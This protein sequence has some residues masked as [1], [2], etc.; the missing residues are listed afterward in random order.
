MSHDILRLFENRSMPIELL[1][2]PIFLVLLQT[3]IWD[4]QSSKQLARR[5]M[6][7][8]ARVGPEFIASARADSIVKAFRLRIWF[9][10]VVEVLAYVLLS[11]RNSLGPDYSV[12]SILILTLTSCIGNS[13]MFGLANREAKREAVVFP[14]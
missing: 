6:F 5:S 10:S 1:F 9:L 2:F 13:I 8:G 12:K 4:W 11:W 3:S 14:G 7:F